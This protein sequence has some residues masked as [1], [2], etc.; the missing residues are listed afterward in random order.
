MRGAHRFSSSSVAQALG[1]W[2]TAGLSAAAF[3]FVDGSD[4][5]LAL[6]AAFAVGELVTLVVSVGMIIA[7][8]RAQ[9]LN[10][11]ALISFRQALPFAANAAMSMVYNRSDVVLV[12][13]LASASVA[14]LYGAASRGQDALYA[15]PAALGAVALPMISRVAD[16][17]GPEAAR[18]LIVR[19]WRFGLAVALPV[20]LVVF[21]AA[22]TIVPWLLGDAY[23]GAVR[24][25][26]VLV[27]FLPLAVIQA[28]ILAGL[29]GIREGGQTT[30]IILVTLLASVV[31]QVFLTPRFGAI[32]AAAASLGRD[33]VATPLALVIGYRFGLIGAHRPTSEIGVTS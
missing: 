1:K 17:G 22:P 29:A 23:S 13:A 14:G 8:P 32:G 15:I 33:V 26:R 6:G 19:F 16:E 7:A 4:R 10:P 3:V 18:K 25:L 12:G 24:P 20:A 21:L 27:W 30:L 9:A 2:S 11:A 5:L 28:P 31:L